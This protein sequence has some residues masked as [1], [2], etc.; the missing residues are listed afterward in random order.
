[1]PIF[2]LGTQ[3]DIKQI[4]DQVQAKKSNY[5]GTIRKGSTIGPESNY[6]RKSTLSKGAA[7]GGMGGDQ[8]S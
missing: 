7:G 2:M 5:F 4:I 3:Q 1:M 8:H 6:R